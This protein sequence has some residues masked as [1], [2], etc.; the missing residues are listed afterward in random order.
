MLSVS[1][2]LLILS[3][4]LYSVVSGFLAPV[5]EVDEPTAN[6][7]STSVN[8][9]TNTTDTELVLQKFKRFLHLEEAY[10]FVQMVLKGGAIV[11]GT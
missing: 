8:Q 7:T 6:F 1:P 5:L 11:F 10:A 4:N 2:K 3:N 9:K